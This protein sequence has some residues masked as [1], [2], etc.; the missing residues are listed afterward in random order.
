M[1]RPDL[2]PSQFHHIIVAKSTES[3]KG[4]LS[5]TMTPISLPHEFAH[6]IRPSTKSS[7]IIHVQLHEHFEVFF[8]AIQALLL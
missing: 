8:P 1:R 7:K 3:K 4:T 6:K 2:Q 5:L